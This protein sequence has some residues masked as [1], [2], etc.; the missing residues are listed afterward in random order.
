MTR[1]L[2]IASLFFVGC[3]TTSGAGGGGSKNTG[4][5]QGKEALE[6]RRNEIFDASKVAN[7]CMKVKQG[8]PVPKG[9]IFAVT[10]S[11]DGKL[12]AKTVK[13]EGTEPMAQC[14]VDTANKTT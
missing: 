7:G 10:A 2:L 8:E 1:Q 6:K 5:F 11:A 13:W 4:P 12:S 14:I 3:A 9:G